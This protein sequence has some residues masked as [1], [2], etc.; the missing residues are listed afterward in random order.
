MTLSDK[1]GLEL[2]TSSAEA[3]GCLDRAVDR[4][5]EYRSDVTS[6][7]KAAL[8]LDPD[9]VLARC[10]MGYLGMLLGTVATRPMVAACLAAIEPV[11]D[12]VTPRERGHVRALRAWFDGDLDRA[13]GEWDAILFARPHDLLALR[14][15]HFAH[16][17]AGRSHG[18]RAATG[19]AL[20]AWSESVPGYGHLLA[21]HAF[22]LE[23]TGDLVGAERVGRQAAELV[24]DDLWA[25]HAVAHVLEVSGRYEEGAAW[26]EPPADGWADRNPFRGHL[27]WHAALFPLE[28]GDHERV[29]ELYDRAIRPGDKPFYL[30]IQNAASL[31]A[32]L[33]FRGVDVGERWATLAEAVRRRGDD[34]A[35]PFTDLHAVLTLARA[36]DRDELA[37]LIADLEASASAAGGRDADTLRRLLLPLAH[38]IAAY[39]AGEPARTLAIVLPIRHDLAAI[40]GSHT[41]R[42]VFHQLLLEAALAAGELPTARHLAAERVTI[43]PESVH[44]WRRWGETLARLGE[45][46]GAASAFERAGSLPRGRPR[47]RAA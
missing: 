38:G 14:L 11:A 13:A 18:L 25:V 2:T 29:L 9:F 47:P 5:L 37:R 17:W 21:M 6:H 27:W 33:E 28:A 36:G 7:V 24:P 12:A 19:A 20:P 45:Q 40:G 35:V 41:Q 32:R 3:A 26:L 16:F 23:E 39:Y 31:L 42:D 4:Y 15:Q 44:S 43:R 34:R 30:D 10:L 8:A 46:A 22:A 1:R